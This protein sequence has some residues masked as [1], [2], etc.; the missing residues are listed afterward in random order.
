DLQAYARVAH[1]RWLKGDLAGAIQ[2]MQLATSAASP[3]DAESAAWANTRLALYEFQACHFEKAEQRCRFA[4]EF[5]NDYPPALLLRGRMRLAENKPA[6]AVDALQVAAKLN[7]LPE[8][9][10]TLAEALSAAHRESEAAAIEVRLRQQGEATDPRTLSMFL[11]TRQQ[12]TDTALR[13]ARA[14]LNARADVFTHDT[15]AWA[16]A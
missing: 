16:L 2:V 8:Y 5:Q 9:Q 15:L 10:W 1:L 7:P 11:A 13:L 6:A 4:L 12:E 3:N 14:E